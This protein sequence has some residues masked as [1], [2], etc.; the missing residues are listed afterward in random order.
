[1]EATFIITL[2]ILTIYNSVYK[3]LSGRPQSAASAP[4]V[5]YLVRPAAVPS[6]WEDEDY[7]Q[8]TTGRSPPPHSDK[9]LSVGQAM[10]FYIQA[11]QLEV[12]A[13]LQMWW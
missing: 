2:F 11:Y 10:V 13:A 1:M 5:Q 9:V 8:Q 6:M 3:Y 12:V 7:D 4:A